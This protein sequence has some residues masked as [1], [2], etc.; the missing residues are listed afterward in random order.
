MQS[1]L[2]GLIVIWPLVTLGLATIFHRKQNSKK[3]WTGGPIS[4]PKSLWL[5]FTVCNW[6]LLPIWFCLHPDFPPPI[7]ML[8]FFHLASWWIR[9]P[10]EL[11]MIYKWLNWTPRYGISH[12]LF[13]IAGCTL[14]LYLAW[15]Q[16]SWSELTPIGFA[17]ISYT[18]IILISTVAEIWFAYLFFTTRTAAETDDNIYFAS[19]DPKWKF[20]NRATASVVTLVYLYLFAQSIYLVLN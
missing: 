20:I 3:A 19:E 13:H 8:Y 9:G 4:W 15:P 17:S 6:F 16:L 5:S 2:L 10:L 1:F 14:F 12:D 11:I 7:K 18:F